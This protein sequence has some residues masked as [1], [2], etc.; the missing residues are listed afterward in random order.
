[1]KQTNNWYNF[2]KNRVNST[3]QLYF[4][5][6]YAPFLLAII[7]SFR[8]KKH[9]SIVE[10]GCGIGSI[11]KFL[12][13]NNISC[14]GI[15]ISQKMCDLANK[16]NTVH[17]NYNQNLFYPIFIKG[18]ILSVKDPLTFNVSNLHVS[19]GVLEHFSDIDILRIIKSIPNSIHYVPLE[20]YKTPSFGDERLLPKEYWIELC[21]PIDYFT[22][23]NGK[24]LV[25]KIK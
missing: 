2:Y 25:F 6:K 13:Y 5:Q 15:D 12:L 10:L 7:Y 3:Y 4:E 18:N 16:N 1:M 20:G 14:W 17:S 8:E 11:S 22:F 24:D 21:N 19:H 23:N 9:N